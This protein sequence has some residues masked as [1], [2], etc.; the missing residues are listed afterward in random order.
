MRLGDD[1]LRA[2]VQRRGVRMTRRK[3]AE[4]VDAA[5]IVLALPKAERATLERILAAD[6]ALFG[7]LEEQLRDAE[8]ELGQV[9]AR[10]PRRGVVE[11]ARRWGGARLELRRRAR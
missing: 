2:Y 10:H 4:V 11:L 5:R 9:L 6:V 7:E 3:A 1:R 8:D